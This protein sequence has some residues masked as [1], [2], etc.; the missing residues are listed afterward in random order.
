MLSWVFDLPVTFGFPDLPGFLNHPLINF[1]SFDLGDKIVEFINSV[2]DLKE[3]NIQNKTTFRVYKPLYI[4]EELINS[5]FDLKKINTQKKTPFHDIYDARF[6]GSLK[7]DEYCA[8]LMSPKLVDDISDQFS[9]KAK[10]LITHELAHAKYDDQETKK[11][12]IDFKRAA[13]V[14]AILASIY[15]QPSYEGLS[16]LKNLLGTVVSTYTFGFFMARMAEIVASRL[17]IQPHEKRAD[18]FAAKLSH[19]IAQGG[20]EVFK[21]TQALKNNGHPCFKASTFLLAIE[22]SIKTLFD[23]HDHPPLQKRIDYLQD[24]I[25]Q[26]YTQASPSEEQEEEFFDCE[27]SM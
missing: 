21:Y 20:V 14:I 23:L 16:I 5:V 22:A 11:S 6:G 25:Q 4:D 17:I 8:L 7:K 9:N 15:F 18:L 12:V 3:M 19:D 27:E 13:Y 2:P 24:Y 1:T 10:F 26:H